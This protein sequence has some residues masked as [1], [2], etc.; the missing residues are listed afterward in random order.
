MNRLRREREFSGMR[1]DGSAAAPLE[2]L[3]FTVVRKPIVFA[4]AIAVFLRSAAMLGYPRAFWFGDSG[5]YVAHSLQLLPNPAKPLGYSIF[6]RTLLPFHSNVLVA[7]IQHVMGLGIGIMVYALLRRWQVR[8]MLAAAAALPVFLDPRQLLIEHSLLSETLFTFCLTGAVVV[9]LWRR[10]LT[11]PTAVLAGLLI[12]AAALTR[13]IGMPLVVVYLALLLVQRVRFRTLLAAIASCLTPLLAYGLWFQ[14]HHGWLTVGANNG[15]ILWSRT[16][17]FADCA[18]IRP[19]ADLAPLCPPKSYQAAG[20]WPWNLLL[21]PKDPGSYEWGPNAW[22]YHTS[23][24]PF[25]PENNSLARRFALHAI[26]AQP[27]D[28]TLVV[29]RD[30]ARAFAMSDPPVDNDSVFLFS[31]AKY[32][33]VQPRAVDMAAMYGYGDTVLGIDRF[34]MF[35]ER[36]QYWVFLPGLGLFAVMAAPMVLA[37]R[38]RRLPAPSVMPWTIAVA[39]VVLAVATGWPEYRYLLPAFPLA[40]MA[41]ALTMAHG[42][43]RRTATNSDTTPVIGTRTEAAS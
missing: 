38:Y 30:L 24:P 20:A 10:R 4:V 19:P 16:M 32:M 6:L 12:A 36:Y 42:K 5:S 25:G 14:V 23:S 3:L 27:V 39:L 7:A 22:Y 26:A 8:P 2:S 1:P 35:L 15:L 29:V 13:S 40:C 31:V 17:S 18:E 37:V 33:G 28:Y 43:A 9:T 41:L 34:Q 21:H 11:V